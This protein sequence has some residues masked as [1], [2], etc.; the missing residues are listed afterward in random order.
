MSTPNGTAAPFPHPV[1]SVP[2]WRTELHKLDNHRSTIDLPTECDILIIGAGYAGV[3]TA[4]HLLKDIGEPPSI[5]LLEAR[6]ACSGAT[7]RNGKLQSR[8]ASQLTMDTGGHLRPEIYFQMPEYVERYG[9]EMAAQISNFEISHIQVFK[10]L[11]EKEK[12]DCDFILTRSMDVFLNEEHALKSKAAYDLLVK[13]GLASLKDVQFIPP[14]NAEIVRFSFS[15]KTLTDTYQISGVKGAKGCFSFTA[16]HIW[17]YKFIMHL[18]SLVVSQG[19]NLQTTTPV[20]SVSPVD[21]KWLISTSRGDIKA[22]KVVFTANG[23]TAGIAPEY[24]HKIVPCRG[25]CC[26]IVAPENR[27]LPLLQNSYSIRSGPGKY[28]YLIARPDG[29]IVVGGAR[30]AF[31]HDCSTWYNVTNDHELIKPAEHYFDGF[32]QRTFRGWEDSGAVTERVWTGSKCYFP[33]NL[34]HPSARVRFPIFLPSS[35][36][37]LF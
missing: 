28:N 31:F 2:F 12:I 33:C 26:R 37:Y 36:S 25:T 34:N 11:V 10:D 30:A 22:T 20:T 5:V 24:T 18:L 4:Y 21:G 16:A 9:L 35:H 13:S 23:Y 3:T 15:S 29:S 8:K 19:I 32:M 27:T 14:K 6:Q 1:S 7:S 17:P